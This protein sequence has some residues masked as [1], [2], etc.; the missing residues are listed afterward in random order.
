MIAIAAPLKIVIP[1]TTKTIKL[2][3]NLTFSGKRA[4]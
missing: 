3:L 4:P 1:T 2:P